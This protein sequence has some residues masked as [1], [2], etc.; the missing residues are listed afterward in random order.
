M[1][2]YGAK[3]DNL[4]ARPRTNRKTVRTSVS[5][6]E[7][8]F[9]EVAKLALHNDVSVAWLVRNA[10]GELLDRRRQDLEPQLPLITPK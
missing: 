1:R 8:M 4:M 6:D 7:R 3:N 2:F 5:L 10:V 9:S